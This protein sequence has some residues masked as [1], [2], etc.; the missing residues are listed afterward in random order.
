[1]REGV[2]TILILALA[3]TDDRA[4]LLGTQTL[5]VRRRQAHGQQMLMESHTGGQL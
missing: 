2:L 3:P 5:D 4:Q 1:M